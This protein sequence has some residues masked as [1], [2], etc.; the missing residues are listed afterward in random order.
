MTEQV[1]NT[2]VLY[3]LARSYATD[4][5]S[6]NAGKMAAQVSHA[7]NSFI[8]YMHFRVPDKH[9][10]HVSLTEPDEGTECE[11][12]ANEWADQ[13]D[14]G[15]GTVLV[16]AVDET[17]LRTAV[18]IANM[19]GFHAESVV[20]PTY[21]YHTSAEMAKLVP[22]DTHTLPPIIDG[23]KAVLFRKETTCAWVF[24]TDKDDPM[25]KAMLGCFPLHP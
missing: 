19:A 9:F 15:F 4:L 1:V 10:M 24:V 6:C 17:Q 8:H 11:R 20:D 18:E 21:P 14:Q 3:I 22:E 16:L 25:A 12:L 2:S 5:P 13:T 7:A 23:N